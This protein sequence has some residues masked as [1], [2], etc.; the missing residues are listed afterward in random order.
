MNIIIKSKIIAAA[1]SGKTGVENQIHDMN[2]WA[3]T[4]MNTMADLEG[5]Y[6][7]RAERK[8]NLTR[9]IDMDGRND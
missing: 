5:T 7:P 2:S 1:W 6:A 4:V 8:D 3:N 9:G